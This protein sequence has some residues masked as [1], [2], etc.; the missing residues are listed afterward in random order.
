[1]SEP[2]P[3]TAPAEVTQ[4]TCQDANPI[5]LCRDDGE[6][7]TA[8][9]GEAIAT[10]PSKV[11][12]LAQAALDVAYPPNSLQR[13]QSLENQGSQSFEEAERRPSEPIPSSTFDENTTP[14]AYIQSATLL[15]QQQQHARPE[16]GGT[17]SSPSISHATHPTRE[18]RQPAHRSSSV[19]ETSSGRLGLGFFDVPQLRPML[20]GT[21]HP[22]SSLTGTLCNT[23][24]SKTS[25]SLPPIDF[26]LRQDM[27]SQP[28][29]QGLFSQAPP[30]PL[31]ANTPP[32]PHTR[33]PTT[34]PITQ[35]PAVQPSPSQP[36]STHHPANHHPKGQNYG[37]LGAR[38][39]S[40][41]NQ[42]H[43]SSPGVPPTHMSDGN[44]A[45]SFYDLGVAYPKGDWHKKL[46]PDLTGFLEKYQRDNNLRIGT[47][48]L[49]IQSG[50]YVC[51]F[52]SES[53]RKPYIRRGPFSSH[54]ARHWASFPK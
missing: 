53:K 2:R 34:E 37:S 50:H 15:A 21:E 11:S 23:E 1:M 46:P 12:R 27:G 14:V 17:H 33:L 35:S 9:H 31:A 25:C 44:N 6:N 45:M 24:A 43:F 36:S 39:S 4:E 20:P 7:R 51:P 38:G 19:A 30:I 5:R 3:L 28:P 40:S 10:G 42:H 49:Q 52:C 47:N 41:T 16:M 22:S 8:A 54:L 13:G 32:S 48:G 29:L 18:E 26:M